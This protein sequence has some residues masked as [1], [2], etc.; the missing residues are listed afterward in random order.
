MTRYD[1]KFVQVMEATECDGKVIAGVH[2]GW[3]ALGLVFTDGT[4]LWLQ[5]ESDFDSTAGITCAAAPDLTDALGMGLMDRAEFDRVV[6]TEKADADRKER[7]EY[8]R[9]RTKF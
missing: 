9:L 6:A 2:H 1:T 5:A 4:F 3:N 7:Q 8:E